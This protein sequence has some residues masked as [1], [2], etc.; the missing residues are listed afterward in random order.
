MRADLAD[1]SHPGYIQLFK[2]VKLAGCLL[3]EEIDDLGGWNGCHEGGI[4]CRDRTDRLRG[5]SIRTLRMLGDTVGWIPR[6]RAEVV[7]YPM[8]C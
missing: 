8:A 6:A 4:R 5:L 2:E 7:S 1:L 3:K